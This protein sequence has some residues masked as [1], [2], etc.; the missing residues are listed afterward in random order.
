MKDKYFSGR[1]GEGIGTCPYCR[2]V[3]FRNLRRTSH[4]NV[5]FFFC[6]RCPHC[7]KNINIR[8]DNDSDVVIEKC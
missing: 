3:I 2:G 4:G 5:S 1:H 6:M 7:Q 8:F